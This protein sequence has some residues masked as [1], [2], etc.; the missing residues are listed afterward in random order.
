MNTVARTVTNK[1]D[2]IMARLELLPEDAVDS[3]DNYLSFLEF[4]LGID[5]DDM[6]SSSAISPWLRERLL[7]GMRTPLSECVPLEDVWDDV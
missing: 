7:E 5:E 3:L 6:E 2:R 4:Q 1:K